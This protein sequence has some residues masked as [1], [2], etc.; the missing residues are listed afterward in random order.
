MVERQRGRA[1]VR[2]RLVLPNRHARGVGE[3]GRPKSQSKG[4]R[5]LRTG[6]MS[7]R[8][9]AKEGYMAKGAMQGKERFSCGRTVARGSQ[10]SFAQKRGLR[11]REGASRGR[12]V[13]HRWQGKVC[14][15]KGPRARER[16]ING[17]AHGA[18][19]YSC[20]AWV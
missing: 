20:H 13:A 5:E 4:V 7:R 18:E 1:R 19:V 10:G 6:E 12:T 15:D 16:G 9:P 17:A 11:E 2:G 8:G 3:V 14:V